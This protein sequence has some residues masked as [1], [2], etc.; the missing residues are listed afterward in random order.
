LNAD[1]G[2]IQV[3][4]IDPKDTTSRNNIRMHLTH[5]AKAFSSGDFAIPMFVHDTVP[6]GVPAM[7]QMK[8][9][10]LYKFEETPAGAQRHRDDRPPSA[11]RHSQIPA[12]PDRGTQD[13]RLKRCT[14]TPSTRKVSPLRFWRHQEFCAHEW[15]DSFFSGQ[16]ETEQHA[17]VFQINVESEEW[18]ALAL[19]DY[20]IR[21]FS[22]RD[23]RGA[24]LEFISLFRLHNPRSSRDEFFSQQFM[25]R[26]LAWIQGLCVAIKLSLRH[27]FFFL[28]SPRDCL[29]RTTH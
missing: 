23:R 4:A 16:S 28:L 3:E 9:K 2:V 24:V 18:A 15:L 19:S 27:C 8:D 17:F 6:P 10:I 5:I 25:M 13:R 20:P 29:Y 1:G 14:V 11:R 21:E 12:I 26:T 7:K 22:E